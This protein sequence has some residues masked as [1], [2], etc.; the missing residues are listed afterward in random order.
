MKLYMCCQDYYHP[1]TKHCNGAE[2]DC[3]QFCLCLEVVICPS[4][5]ISASRMV[6]A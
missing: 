4:C 1:C 3:P 2:K 6:R 5:S